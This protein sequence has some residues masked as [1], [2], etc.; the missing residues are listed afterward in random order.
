M[1]LIS[2]ELNRVVDH[3]LRRCCVETNGSNTSGLEIGGE[4]RRFFDMFAPELDT[5]DYHDVK[6]VNSQEDSTLGEPTKTTDG[7]ASRI[8]F[9]FQ[10]IR[11]P[12]TL[13]PM[14]IIKCY[15]NLLDR[16]RIVQGL[17]HDLS[18]QFRTTD[19]EE[20]KRSCVCVLKSSNELVEQGSLIAEILFQ[21]IAQ[22]SSGPQFNKHIY[23]QQKRQKSNIH[24]GIVNGI[25]FKSVFCYTQSLIEWAG[26]T[27]DF[28]EIVVVLEDPENIPSPNLDIFFTTIS[29]LRSQYGVPISL[30]IMNC[31]PGLGDRLST[32]RQ[33][34][35]YGGSGDGGVMQ[36]VLTLPL[37]EELFNIFM[38]E[39]MLRQ[40]IPC[41]FWDNKD[42]MDDMQDVFHEFDNSIVGAARRLKTELSR[43]FSRSG[44]FASL[45]HCKELVLPNWDR[46]SWMA[47][48]QN[49]TLLTTRI[50]VS[51]AFCHLYQTISS[52]ENLRSTGTGS[53]NLVKLLQQLHRSR[54]MLTTGHI[55]DSD[56]MSSALV[57]QKINEYIILVGE[58]LNDKDIDRDI[59]KILLED[60]KDW[61]ITICTSQQIELPE[62]T[63]IRASQPRK[64][65]VKAFSAPI[66]SSVNNSIV[67]AMRVAFQ[68]FDCRIL[69]LSK[70]Y[71]NYFEIV[72]NH[73]EINSNEC[74]FFLAIQELVHCGF[75]RKLTSGRRKEDAYEK[76]AMVWGQ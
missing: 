44:A 14:I 59:M 64:D 40:C 48:T 29:S 60:M 53:D 5:P 52:I 27:M 4:C 11:Y 30:V 35:F 69:T 39:L 33:P 6:Q 13:L 18:R 9:S 41:T 66:P 28:D 76:I 3:V 46:I 54:V 68:C 62:L 63:P 10:P 31:T 1:R 56:N 12:P 43:Y 2:L 65:V 34:A 26:C 47:S 72:T 7:T 25:L 16:N 38:N 36:R 22:D 61:A 24:G 45:L 71:N 49:D 73:P 75:I 37:P 57:I 42:V 50:L 74:V 51:L 55:I 67:H 32:L 21:C 17:V 19:G 70:W 8:R 23:K 20:K 15:P 58:T